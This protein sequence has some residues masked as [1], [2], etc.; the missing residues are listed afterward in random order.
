MK[1]QRIRVENY[2][3]LRN[4]EIAVREHLV[5]VGAND[6]G[7]SS[8][9]R[10]VD[11]ALRAN[12]AQLYANVTVDDFRDPGEPL[13]IEIELTDFGQDERAYFPDEI[14]VD[15][16]TSATSLTI[17]LRA[18]ADDKG[19]LTIQRIAPFGGT[20]RQISRDQLDGLGWKFLS[21]TASTRD[22]REDRRSAV[23]DLLRAIEL[24]DEQRAFV[25]VAEQFQVQL[26]G[27][28]RLE[29]LRGR[30][31]EQL[32]K[33][34]PA[35]LDAGDLAFV[36]GAAA[37]EDVLNDVRL[38]ITKEG[39]RHDLSEQSDGTRALFAIALYDLMTVGAHVVGIDEPEIHLHPT[40]QRSLARL[41]RSSSSQKVLA[42]H[43]SD[44]VGAFDPDSIVVVRRGGD[45]VQPQEGF[46]SDDEKTFVRWW[47]RDRLEPLTAKRVIAVEGI[48]D[49]IILERAAELTDRHLDRLGACVLE[50]R[51]A[52][53]MAPIDK[54][55]GAT[56]FGI[57]MSLLID[58]DAEQATAE[59]FGVSVDDLPGRS[60]W[61]SDADLE[62]EYVEALGPQVVWDAISNG[63]H[64]APNQL[65]T[66]A[67]T[68]EGGMRT[69]ADVAEFCRRKSDFKVRAALSVAPV[70][71]ETTARKIASV[72]S[73]LNEIAN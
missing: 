50:A 52:N 29:A 22:I 58:K 31:A 45:V 39:E 54:L 1:L 14:Y 27:S 67:A 23:D 24:G 56:G 63:G 68:G 26:D 61:V 10:A 37:T 38:Q 62:D 35:R 40:S 59:K 15:P 73:L 42:T 19:S 8:L 69:A 32:S 3:R 66:C 2:R 7:K 49:R 6:V 60:V 33:A 11:L 5:L 48:S 25:A 34:L 12:A 65:S 20:G 41:L 53:E 51:G 71:T 28:K 46:M 47:V 64:F 70:L 44:I 21:A 9:L 16:Q 57:P 18:E 17:Q 36:T 72:E 30:L 4:F 55:F 43:S 13:V